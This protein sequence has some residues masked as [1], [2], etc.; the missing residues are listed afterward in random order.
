MD[1]KVIKS[2]QCSHAVSIEL[3]SNQGLAYFR[4]KH[5]LRSNRHRNL[6]KQNNEDFFIQ[7]VN[8]WLHFTSNNF[9]VPTALEKILDQP[10][11]SNP[12]TKLDFS[13]D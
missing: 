9:P 6:Q 1:S 2:Y 13:S 5:I 7:L 10:I 12:H 3:N 4:Q 11:F 8:A